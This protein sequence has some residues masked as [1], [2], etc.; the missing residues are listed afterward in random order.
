MI[1]TN[2]IIVGLVAGIL[3]FVFGYLALE[4]YKAQT[5]ENYRALGCT[6]TYEDWTKRTW[7]CPDGVSP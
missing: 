6:M 2:S 1:S 7:D 5:A 3:V 4:V